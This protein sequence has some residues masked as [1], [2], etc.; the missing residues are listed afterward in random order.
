[1]TGSNVE[2]STKDTEKLVE[3]EKRISIGFRLKD[4]LDWIVTKL[5]VLLKEKEDANNR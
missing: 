4:D 5:R 2:E 3:I 1:M